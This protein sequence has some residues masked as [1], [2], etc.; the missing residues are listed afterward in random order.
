[1][2]GR[3]RFWRSGPVSEASSY[4]PGIEYFGFGPVSGRFLAGLGPVLGWFRASFW[5]VS[6][7][8]LAGF[9]PV[10]GWFRAG[11]WPASAAKAN[12]TQKLSD[13]SGLSGPLSDTRGGSRY[14]VGGTSQ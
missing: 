6:G 7:R 4:K 2:K 8:F 9:G 13:L 5:L 10:F 1:M 11:F 12:P 14:Q 3:G